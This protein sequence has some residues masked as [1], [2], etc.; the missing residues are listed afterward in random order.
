[1][2]KI[3]IGKNLYL[4]GRVGWKGLKKSEYLNSGEYRIINALALEENK[5]NWNKAGYI[6]KERY[7]ESPEIMLQKNDIL[8]SK[9]GTLG[10]IGYVD[11][12]DTKTT[13][14]SGIFLLRNTSPEAIDTRYLYQLLKSNIFKDFIKNNKAEGSTINHLYQADL[15]NFEVD[16]PCLSLQ[17]SISR[18][19]DSIDN[20]ISINNKI[21][22]NLLNMAQDIYMHY[23]FKKSPNGKLNDIILESDKSKIQVGDA[24]NCIGQYPFFTSG[25]SI[26]TW[27]EYFVDGRY[28]FLNTGGNA[29]VKFYAGKSAYSTDTWCIYTNNNMTDYMYLL[30]LTLKEELNKKYFQGTGLKHLQKDL[31][32]NKDIYIPTEIELSNFNNIIE[33]LFNN[34]SKNTSEIEKLVGLRD[35]LLPLLMNGQ[36]KI[37]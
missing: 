31:L 27:N 13:I 7:E 30:L 19:L 1:M 2:S 10:K 11:E 17:N 12:L 29:D 33:P 22:D 32:K 26:L 28:C 15:V 36:A 37:D 5:I 14:A 3:S 18:I 23:F 6:S 25:T 24:K 9:D 34:I 21:N 20:K 16:F 35:F 8:I 4:K